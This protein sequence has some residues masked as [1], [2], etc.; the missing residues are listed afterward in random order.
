MLA[1]REALESA[2]LM[3]ERFFIYSEEPDLC[4]RIKQAGWDVRHVPWMTILHHVNKAGINPKLEAQDAFARMQHARKHFSRAHR[5]AYAGALALRHVLR[6]AAAP[7][8]P[9]T[10]DI[11][12]E[13]SFRALRAALGREEPP[14]GPP[15][16][17]AL[18]L[19]AGTV[20]GFVACQDDEAQ[21]AAKG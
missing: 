4:Y 11:R 6:A 9:K 17:Q 10:R 21:P 20:G 2:G 5:V 3:D 13:A 8:E 18:A 7:L 16:R 15:P 14:F 12:R 19:R 1:R